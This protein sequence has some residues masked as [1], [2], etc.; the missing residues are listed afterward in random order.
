MKELSRVVVVVILAVGFSYIGGSCVSDNGGRYGAST[1]EYA[2]DPRYHRIKKGENLYRISLKYGVSVED[3]KRYNNIW[4]VHDIKVGTKI[5]I[6]PRAYVS[7][8]GGQGKKWYD[9]T[10]QVEERGPV[11]T[12]IKFIWPVRRVD[13]SSPFGIR[14]DGKHTGVDLR[15]PKGTPIMAAAGGR[16]IFSGDGPSGYGNTIMIKHDAN[17]IT[18]YA[19]NSKNMVR[20]NDYVNQGQ[21]VAMVGM[22]GRAT[23][24][25]VH[26]EIRINRK[27]VNPA[28]LLPRL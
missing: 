5:Y 7:R 9:A 13:I 3:L 2:S 8:S 4:N 1:G 16:V 24:Y 17:T 25:H 12:N 19:H 6:P 27:P 20:E 11:K 15:N 26:F 14:K 21:T 22:T 28:N 18:V 23:G 10:Q